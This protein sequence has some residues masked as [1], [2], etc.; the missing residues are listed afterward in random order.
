M[1]KIKITQKEIEDIYEV[2][3]ITGETKEEKP[4]SQPPEDTTPFLTEAEE[5]FDIKMHDSLPKE[6]VEE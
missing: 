6:E 5:E 4:S 1:D 3:E 2:E